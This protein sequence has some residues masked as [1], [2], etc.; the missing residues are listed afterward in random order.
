MYRYTS[1][2]HLWKGEYK[3]QRYMGN[4][5][6]LCSASESLS[7]ANEWNDM[8]AIYKNYIFFEGRLNLTWNY[9]SRHLTHSCWSYCI[10]LIETLIVYATRTMLLKSVSRGCIRV[11]TTFALLIKK[12]SLL[13]TR[14]GLP[15]RNSLF[16]GTFL[17]VSWVTRSVTYA[18]VYAS[19]RS[20]TWWLRC[21]GSEGA[22]GA[23]IS[24]R[25]G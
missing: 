14:F 3:K 18:V 23:H 8:R 24:G 12:S 16:L 25:I 21:S 6:L 2:I 13:Y 15:M 5:Y 17:V 1:S 10:L 22:A 4:I 9:F 19:N 11:L 20:F 7:L